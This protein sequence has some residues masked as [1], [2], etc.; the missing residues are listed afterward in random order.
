MFK[1]IAADDPV[2][3]PST[4]HGCPND[5]ANF[6]CVLNDTI[7]KWVWISSDGQ[8][9]TRSYSVGSPLST[10]ALSGVSGVTTTLRATGENSI[11]TSL[12][13]ILSSI[14]INARIE[15]A[16][17]TARRA[18]VTVLAESEYAKKHIIF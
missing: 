8:S 16:G 14:H 6:I 11:I 3:T 2:I 9:S 12:Q 15:C 13:F 18:V 17:T 5:S 1:T 7:M 4:Y 10:K